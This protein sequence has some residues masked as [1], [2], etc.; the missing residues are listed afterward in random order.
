[1]GITFAHSRC[2][3][4]RFVLFKSNS[5][6][7]LSLAVILDCFFFLHISGTIHNGCA[8][9][10]KK[11]MFACVRFVVVAAAVYDWL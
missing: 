8:P 1:M 7:F 9:V 11:K 10:Q 5:N 3:H 4:P 2:V 6:I